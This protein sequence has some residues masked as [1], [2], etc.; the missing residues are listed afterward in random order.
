MT[1]KEKLNNTIITNTSI[2][3]HLELIKDCEKI[4]EEFAVDF[5]EWL[6][7]QDI[8]QRGKNNFICT[9]GFQRSTAELLEIYKKGA[10]KSVSI[11]T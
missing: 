10:S 5:A 4:A 9:D 1:L 8:T 11:G 7:N 3:N 2:M 6:I